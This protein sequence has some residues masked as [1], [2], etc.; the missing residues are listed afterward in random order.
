MN[1]AADTARAPR[2]LT[3]DDLKQ[4]ALHIKDLA[5]SETR[6]VLRQDATKVLMVGAVAVVAVISI[7]YFLGARHARGAISDMM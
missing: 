7:A 4:K 5:E 3:V 2:Q 6:E 1:E